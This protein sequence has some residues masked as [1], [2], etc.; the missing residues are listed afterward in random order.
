[1]RILLLLSIFFISSSVFS[2]DA[3]KEITLI[4]SK[5]KEALVLL[6]HEKYEDFFVLML[7]PS[8]IAN[9]KEQGSYESAIT[10]FSSEKKIRME[11]LIEE[12]LHS[13]L[14]V[15]FNQEKNQVHFMQRK[16][17]KHYVTFTNYNGNWYMENKR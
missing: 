9:L 7:K 11:S 12:L 2:F 14:E 1:M 10:K 15:E 17:K 6:E 5:L 4:N 16:S 8:D 13:D 3:E